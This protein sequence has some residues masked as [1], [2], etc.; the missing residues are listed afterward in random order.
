MRTGFSMRIEL[1]VFPV[2]LLE[3]WFAV[4]LEFSVSLKG[5][6]VC[7]YRYKLLTKSC[8]K[9]EVKLFLSADILSIIFYYYTKSLVNATFGSGKKSC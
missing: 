6:A 5:F 3:F 7:L 9:C 4:C 2:S 1:K 8:C